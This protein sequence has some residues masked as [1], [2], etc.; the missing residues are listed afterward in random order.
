V[1]IRT[2]HVGV[3]GRGRWP[4]D[5]M[6][7]DPHY[8]P[9]AVVD[10]T[11]EVAA[12]AKATLGL[13]EGRAFSDVREALRH[14]D[15]DAVVIC[16]PTRAHAELCRM[17]F[18][19][20][21]HVLV[22][23]GMTHSLD[24]ARSLVREADSAGVK[25]CVAQNHRYAASELTISRLLNDPSHPCHPGAVKS[26]DYI[27]HRYRPEPR[28]LDYPYAMVWDM[29]CH[30][31][32]SLSCWLGE[33][34]RVTAVSSNPP[35]SAYRHDADIRAVIEYQSGAVCSYV[36]THAATA[37]QWNVM[38]QG[39]RGALRMVERKRVEFYRKPETQLGQSDA[40]VC[41]LLDAPGSE[42]GVANAFA[43]YVLEGVEPGISGRNNLKTLDVC[44][45]LVRSARDRRS[46]DRAEL[47]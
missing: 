28:T 25:F 10:V 35:W 43:R 30:H 1:R 36:L 26:V 34:Q 4:I 12:T 14:V 19:A 31:L 46:V 5:V 24:E 29:G 32:D 17:A 9:V 45:M 13:G 15:A 3:G 41:P 21:R 8:Q 33:A 42:Q 20:H 39:D 27:H 47:G 11:P 7:K 40:I 23:K 37:S 6:G 38:L 22:E 16:T 2:I 44:E 18:A